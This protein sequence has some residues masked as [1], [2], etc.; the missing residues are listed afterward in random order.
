MVDQ[1]EDVSMTE[2]HWK[3]VTRKIS[4]SQRQ[5]TPQ[6]S[7]WSKRKGHSSN[8]RHEQGMFQRSQ[9]PSVWRSQDPS[10]CDLVYLFWTQNCLRSQAKW[11]LGRWHQ[12]MK[13]E[14]RALPDNKI[15]SLMR[16]LR[17]RDI[18]MSKWVCKVELGPSGQVDKDKARYLKGFK[19]VERLDSFGT[20]APT[21]KP[22]TFKILFQ[23]ST[24]QGNVMHQFGLKKALL[25]P[26]IEEE[27]YLEQ[28]LESA[29]QWSV[30]EKLLCWQNKSIYGLKQSANNL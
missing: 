26:P 16:P 4:Q 19:Q 15:W 3:T 17:D 27:V 30:G 1:Q 6:K 25:H 8:E 24:T 21:C 9:D 10:C 20:F 28:P 14:V 13:D 7:H 23:L 2:S 18:I 12:V 5:L 29:K 22:K 11:R